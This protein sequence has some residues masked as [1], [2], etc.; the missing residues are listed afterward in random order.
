MGMYKVCWCGGD[1]GCL[2]D[3]HYSMHV[4]TLIINGMMLTV[5][6]D[7]RTPNRTSD[8]IETR[9]NFMWRASLHPCCIHAASMRIQFH[10][11]F[12]HVFHSISNLVS[13]RRFN[14]KRTLP[15]IPRTSPALA[16]RWNFVKLVGIL[17]MVILGTTHL[18]QSLTEPWAW[19]NTGPNITLW[20]CYS[21]L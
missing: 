18:S 1:G 7:G 9:Q 10:A 4:A 8:M 5:A 12:G 15:R 11:S 13:I 21:L 6:G 19:R 17:R 2:E 16:L 20:L 14:L 3:E